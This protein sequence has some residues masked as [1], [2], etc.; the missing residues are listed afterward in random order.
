M[1]AGKEKAGKDETIVLLQDDRAIWCRWRGGRVIEQRIIPHGEDAAD[2]DLIPFDR[3]TVMEA[4]EYTAVSLIL[5]SSLDEVNCMTSIQLQKNI[6]RIPNDV[7]LIHE[8]LNQQCQLW[9]RKVQ[10]QGLVFN[11]V[12]STLR[13]LLLNYCKGVKQ[14]FIVVDDDHLSRHVLCQKG[15]M[16]YARQCDNVD[17]GFSQKALAESLEYLNGPASV[18]ISSDCDIIYIGADPD[19][20]ELLKGL[21]ARSV[22]HETS[23][24]A[25]QWYFELFRGQRWRIRS[26]MFSRQLNRILNGQLDISESKRKLRSRHKK[27]KLAT[28]LSGGIASIAVVIVAVHG[29]S[30]A[31]YLRGV[32][33]KKASLS[34]EIFM[35]SQSATAIHKSPVQ[36]AESIARLEQ[37]DRVERVDAAEVLT[38]VADTVTQHPQ[39]MLDHLEWLI[40]DDE[41]ALQWIDVVSLENASVPSGIGRVLRQSLD[42]TE[43]S[44][45]MTGAQIGIEGSVREVTLRDRHAVFNKFVSSLETSPFIASVK[46][47]TSPLEH[48]VSSNVDGSDLR[49]SL[50]IL[51]RSS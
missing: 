10:E 49:F 1:R 47:V 3:M 18:T 37:F 12:V 46:V 45:T 41:E 15:R 8:S 30:A 26:K 6:L 39:I 19:R 4:F 28:R 5:D 23:I 20:L 42:D 48:A 43:V 13:L 21:S 51:R 34:N 7:D 17:E 50:Q 44:R 24:T 25:A 27:L 36:A 38:L 33:A 14:V 2:S 29:I 9:L 31:N 40:I 16:V 32:E 22:F 35:A 11:C